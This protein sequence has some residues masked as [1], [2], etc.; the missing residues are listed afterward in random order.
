[1]LKPTLLKKG[2]RQSSRLH[3]S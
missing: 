2:L 3:S 1:L